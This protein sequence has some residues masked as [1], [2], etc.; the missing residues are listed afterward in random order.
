MVL[1]QSCLMQINKKFKPEVVALM[2][3][4]VR[5]VRIHN[6]KHNLQKEDCCSISWKGGSLVILEKWVAV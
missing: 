2:E 1:S 6:W 3:P 4:F 5:V